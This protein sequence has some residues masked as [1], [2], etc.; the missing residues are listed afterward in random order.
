VLQAARDVTAP[1]R[2]LISTYAV[3]LYNGCYKCLSVAFEEQAKAVPIAR[4]YSTA[5]RLRQYFFYTILI[6]DNASNDREA[7][8]P[9]RAMAP[10]MVG[11]GVRS[12]SGARRHH[13]GPWRHNVCQSAA[14]AT[15]QIKGGGAAQGAHPPPGP[16]DGHASTKLFFA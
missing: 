6:N 4:I 16:P 10:P 13:K 11:P 8:A 5:D 1:Q 12:F 2:P 14:A 3:T 9:P 15:Q 7:T